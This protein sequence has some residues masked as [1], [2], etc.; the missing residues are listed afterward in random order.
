VKKYHLYLDE[1]ESQNKDRTEVSFCLAGIIVEESKMEALENKLINL[2][3]SIWSATHCNPKEIILHEMDVRKVQKR[4]K[5]VLET[6][7]PLF[8][9]FKARK[10]SR[11]LYDGISDIIKESDCK[12]IGA[13]VHRQKLDN[14][15]KKNP[16][17]YRSLNCFSNNIREFLS[18]LR[19]S[20]WYR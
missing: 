17:N 2:K 13:S 5:R 16:S 9:C 18:F 15:F 19:F 8:H 6:I 14:H 4:N 20:K 10:Y 7:D 12:I 3:E 1:S 11:I